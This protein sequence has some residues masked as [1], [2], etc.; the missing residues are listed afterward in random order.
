ML[1][2]I[3]LLLQIIGDWYI[4]NMVTVSNNRKVWSV[5]EKFKMTLQIQNKKN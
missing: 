1:P 3:F 5:E 2:S 4:H